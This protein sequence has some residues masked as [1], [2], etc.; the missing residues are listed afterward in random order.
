MPKIF[1]EIILR[2]KGAF[3][4]IATIICAV[5]VCSLNE[6][7]A[8]YLTIQ[9]KS[10]VRATIRGEKILIEG[11]Y[12]IKNDGDE[13][14]RDVFPEFQLGSESWQESKV[15]L[16]AKSQFRWTIKREQPFSVFNSSKTVR[17]TVPLFALRHYDDVNGYSYTA[18]DVIPLRFGAVS[19]EE[20]LKLTV[21]LSDC[22]GSF[23][24]AAVLLNESHRPKKVH[25]QVFT[26]KEFTATIDQADAIIE[27]GDSQTIRLQGRDISAIPTSSY[28]VFVVATWEEGDV[29]QMV[30]SFQF[31]NVKAQTRTTQ[32][33]MLFSASII[34]PLMCY[35]LSVYRRPRETS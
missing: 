20:E 32:Y 35:L 10:D 23:A 17:G 14:A 11:S 26:T 9:A 6:G 33:L 1:L 3:C 19:D 28:A 27:S 34:V 5:C 18:P 12:E 2:V 30:S 15:N 8:T 22:S 13:E 4:S 31:V 29:L 25:L 7:W 16:P 21:T 24:G